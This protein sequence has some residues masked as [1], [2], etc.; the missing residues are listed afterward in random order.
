MKI[1][2]KIQMGWYLTSKRLGENYSATT[3]SADATCIS[4]T[5]PDPGTLQILFL[6]EIPLS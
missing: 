1:L 4:K 3:L 2:P 5:F 6:P